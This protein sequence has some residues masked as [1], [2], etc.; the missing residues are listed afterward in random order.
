MF[1]LVSIFLLINGIIKMNSGNK[2]YNGPA[3]IRHSY[4]TEFLVECPKCTLLAVVTVDNPYSMNNGCLTCNHCLHIEKA[5]DLIRYNAIVKRYCDHC[6]KPFEIT[7]PGQKDKVKEVSVAC[8]HCKIARTYKPRNQL[9]KI[10]YQSTGKAAD[11]VFGLPLW[12]QDKVNDHLFWA[13]N[14][15]HLNDIKA[16][17]QAKLRERQGTWYTTMVEKLPQFIKAAKNRDLVLKI[18]ERLENK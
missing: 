1:T 13:Y 12:L 2:R 9:Y 5:I 18:I 8:P 4:K 3:T 16:Y 6:G 14:R 15:N 17:V 11:P 10:G 7:I